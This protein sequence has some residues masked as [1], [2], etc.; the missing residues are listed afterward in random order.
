MLLGAHRTEPAFIVPTPE[1]KVP[2]KG[3]FT[4]EKDESKDWP[5][6]NKL[7]TY[8]NWESADIYL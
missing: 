7:L 4:K 2:K 3:G 5:S 6:K 1:M 8:S